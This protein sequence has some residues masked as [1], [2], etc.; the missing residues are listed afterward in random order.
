VKDWTEASDSELRAYVS[1][2]AR[3]G[4][5]SRSHKTFRIGQ[6][7]PS[8]LG[9]LQGMLERMQIKSWIYQ[10]GASRHYWVLETSASFL[11]NG[12]TSFSSR[13]DKLAFARGYFDSDG[14]MPR[15]VHARLYFQY[16]QKNRDDLASLRDTLICEGIKCG[17]LHNPSWRVDPDYWRF[18]I[19]AESHRDFMSLVGSWHPIK[20]LLMDE[21]MGVMHPSDRG[22][23][24]IDL[25]DSSPSR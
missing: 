16:C 24:P 1:G 19:R 12:G 7:N 4:T 14:G 11:L 2:A 22:R 5:Q 3:D 23:L 17:T 25:V 10:E 18:F 21:R 9:T 13:P 6:S 8:W 15:H 20:G